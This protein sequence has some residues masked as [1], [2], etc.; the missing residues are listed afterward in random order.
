MSTPTAHRVR[1]SGRRASATGCSA[2]SK[3][4]N[5]RPREHRCRFALISS[6]ERNAALRQPI[7]TG[8]PVGS[9]AYAG[10]VSTSERAGAGRD[11]DVLADRSW[12]TRSHRETL[13]ELV[14]LGWTPLG[15]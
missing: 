14:L 6:A 13:A 3:E 12:G 5:D 7:G 2:V 4:R 15:V 8:Q 1:R 10:R 9:L 11:V